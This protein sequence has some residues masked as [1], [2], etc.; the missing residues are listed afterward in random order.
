M[1]MIFVN[2][3]VKD[4]EA[5]KAFF[6][7]LGFGHNPQFSDETA[8]CIVIDENIF[9][10][11]MSHEKFSDFITGEISDAHKATE[12]LTCLSANSR[13]E[14]D[15]LLAKALAAGAKP[16]KPIMDMGP[17]YGASFQDPDGHVWELMYMDMAAME[18][19][20]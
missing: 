13:E 3:P 19:A 18:E 1:R 12:V 15:D 6:A 2:L 10:M 8:A 17:M 14:V 20:G 9:A 16:W 11:V 4:V 5:S 7:A